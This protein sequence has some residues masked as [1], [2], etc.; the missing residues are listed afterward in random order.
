[1]N[2]AQ[3]LR[4]CRLG[5]GKGHK[6]N[7]LNDGCICGQ[8]THESHHQ[9]L[10]RHM[11]CRRPRGLAV[12][13][14]PVDFRACELEDQEIREGACS[15]HG[16]GEEEATDLAATE[17]AATTRS[18]RVKDMAMRRPRHPVSDGMRRR[19][20]GRNRLIYGGCC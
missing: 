10:S 19:S 14:T 15:L 2:F 3:G 7:S 17:L 9:Y 12:A 18:T 6:R 1:L 8:R 20:P 5:P 4:I 11:P 16:L 13:G